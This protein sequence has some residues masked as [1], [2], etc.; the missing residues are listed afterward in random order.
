MQ[1]LDLAHLARVLTRDPL[2]GVP[3]PPAFSTWSKGALVVHFQN[4]VFSF[5]WGMV[6]M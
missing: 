6:G 1:S 5:D 4:S 3:S 2:S